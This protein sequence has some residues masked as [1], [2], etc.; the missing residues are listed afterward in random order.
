MNKKT[1]KASSRLKTGFKS[2]EL[3]MKSPKTAMRA[4]VPMICRPMFVEIQRT[5]T[6]IMKPPRINRAKPQPSR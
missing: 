3:T 2:K 6:T 1:A 5:A 4:N